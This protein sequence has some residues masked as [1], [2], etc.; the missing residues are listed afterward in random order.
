MKMTQKSLKIPINPWQWPKISKDPKQFMKISQRIHEKCSKNPK[1]SQRILTD[2]TTWF[3]NIKVTNQLH[4]QLLINS[5]I[6][7]INEL[8]H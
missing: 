7:L 6:Q 8:I 3:K 2:V 1:R 5:L 4:H